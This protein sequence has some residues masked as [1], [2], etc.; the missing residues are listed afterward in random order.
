MIDTTMYSPLVVQ[1]CPNKCKMADGRHVKK[2]KK[3]QHLRNGFTDLTKFGMVM[4]LGP[5]T[6]SANV[7]AI[8]CTVIDNKTANINDKNCSLSTVLTA[9]HQKLQKND[10]K[11]M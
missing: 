9:T 1:K 3:S 4:R 11:V 2:I 10:K 7:S 5:L 6:P 8:K